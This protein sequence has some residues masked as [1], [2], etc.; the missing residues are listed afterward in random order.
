MVLAATAVPIEFRSPGQ[1]ALSSGFFLP[2][3]LANITGY[4]PVGIVLGALGPAYA[5]LV[6]CLMATLAETAQFVMM[7]R[8]PSVVD[9]VANVVGAALG[10]AVRE[11]WEIY[12]PELGVSRKK[13]FVA[14]TLAGTLILVIWATSGDAPN[15]RGATSPGTLEAH[16]KFDHSTGGVALDSS[17]HG[18][19]GRSSKT[20]MLVAG[21]LGR[22]VKL[23]GA[24]DYI[25]FGRSTALRLVGS[26]TVTAWID[27]SSF[28]VDDA[29]I[30]SSHNG[31][32]YQ[33]DTTVDRG[34]RTIGFKLA[35]ACGHLMARYGATPLV[36]DTWY[37]VAGVYDAAAQTL[38]VYLNGRL[39][40]GFLLG[41]VTGA[42]RSSREH[43]FV[44]R[45]SNL[46]GYEF[47]GHIDDVRIYSRAL[48]IP[49]IS[50]VMR[51]TVIDDPGIRHAAGGDTPPGR[52]PGGSG[53]AA[54]FD[55]EDAQI[56]GAAAVLG[57]LVAVAY[58]GFWPSAG[59]LLCL[60]VS[61][62][63]GLLLLSSTAASLP[64]L[65]SW[66]IPLTSLAGG[67]SVVASRFRHIRDV[68]HDI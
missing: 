52:Q 61:F 18:L 60:A 37:H 27:P 1:V 43:V 47:A 49:E 48:T 44:G 57:V 7:L 5:L 22:A 56:P 6:A 20:S 38:D 2:D 3:V 32:G 4:V 34:P 28:P 41:S 55:R 30:V 12:S 42:Q 59:S 29:A 58:A 8:D 11:A 40:N 19:N 54:L 64:S 50:D 10:L 53:C 17:G 9:V 24:T 25:D 14:A 36:V 26:M 39:D 16:W 33:L 35:D 63:A 46:K 15:S 62:I 65:G 51:G 68:N 45:R 21:I 31:L 66:L 13:G 23:D 67:A